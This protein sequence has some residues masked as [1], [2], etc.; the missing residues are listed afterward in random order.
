VEELEAFRG[1]RS[2]G[3]MSKMR[4]TGQ[5]DEPLNYFSF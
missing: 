2:I 1:R 5:K 3:R 4:E